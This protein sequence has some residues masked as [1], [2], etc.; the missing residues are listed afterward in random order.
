MDDTKGNILSFWENLAV[1]KPVGKLVTHKDKNQVS[2]EMNT[3]L[4]L[5]KK[6]DKLL[7]VGSGNGFATSIYAKKCLKTVGLDYSKSMIESARKA[8]QYK[9]LT[10]E[11]G[12]VL[13]LKYKKGT[14]SIVVSTRC[15]I[16][17][18]S[19]EAQKKALLNI[20]NILNKGGRF[21]LAEGVK[22]GRTNLNR[23]RKKMALPLMPRVWHN[24]DFDEDK[25]FPFLDDLFIIKQD[26]RFGVYDAI[27]RVYYPACIYP[28]EPHFGK[29]Y[30]LQAENLFYKLGSN[31]LREY[32][33]EFC[34]EL[35]K[36]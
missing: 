21:I 11:K 13:D 18:T 27:T 20:Y 8:F 22:Q 3:I 14:F 15:L 12:D 6:S 1:S 9:K 31:I 29:V 32:S 36:K 28:K 34:L 5:L 10:F 25:L 16:N 17:L 23:L 24:R 33:R 35:V 19:W 2:I 26:I 30:Q 7:D 4:R